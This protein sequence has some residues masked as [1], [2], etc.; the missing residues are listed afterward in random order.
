M[1][2]KTRVKFMSVALDY[3]EGNDYFCAARIAVEIC[4]PTYLSFMINVYCATKKILVGIQNTQS[5]RRKCRR[6]YGCSLGERD[7]NKM[8]AL[9]IGDCALAMIHEADFV[10]MRRTA[11]LDAAEELGAAPKNVAQEKQCRRL[12][13]MG[14]GSLL[15]NYDSFVALAN[16]LD[17]ADIIDRCGA[18]RRW[19]R[20]LLRLRRRLLGE[21]RVRIAAADLR[22]AAR[23]CVALI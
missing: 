20:L 3:R 5:T 17:V 6:K 10:S 4:A 18:E 21:L 14:A 2:V 1:G 13:K 12:R 7:F 16:T 8:N 11:L 15:T 9:T 23:H 19:R 22:L